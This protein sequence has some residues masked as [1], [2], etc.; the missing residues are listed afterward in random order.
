MHALLLLLALA[1]P[2]TGQDGAPPAPLP[3]RANADSVALR[4]QAELHLAP[5]QLREL[6]GLLVWHPP[7]PPHAA[8]APD[9]AAAPAKAH[10]PSAVDELDP[11]VISGLLPRLDPDQVRA[12]ARLAGPKDVQAVRTLAQLRRSAWNDRPPLVVLPSE[13]GV[14]AL[15]TDAGAAAALQEILKKTA[16]LRG[17]FGRLGR[18]GGLGLGRR[19]GRG[20]RGGLGG[21]GF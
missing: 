4:V 16:K 9:P 18:F 10:V 14:S 7:L 15:H 21:L 19:G 1:L 6:E 20:R 2:L 3:P 13:A 17:R 8:P 12:L 11:L 5:R